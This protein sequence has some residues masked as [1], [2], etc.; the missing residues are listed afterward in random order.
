M[1]QVRFP[2]HHL[3]EA[4]VAATPEVLFAFLDDHA[5]LV[6]HME[7]PSLMTAGGMFRVETDVLHGRGVGAGIRMSG[8][9]LGLELRVE[10]VVTE[11]LPPYSKTWETRSEPRL[12]VIGPYRMGFI[13]APRDGGSLVKVFIDYRLPERGC[14]RLFGRLL[15]KSYAE[16]CTR[17]MTKDAVASFRIATVS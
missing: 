9:V 1:S 5:R 15:G 16:W 14:A 17:R 13:I 8:A 3:S 7:R 12:L 4:T 10:E 11:Y 2:L 6:R